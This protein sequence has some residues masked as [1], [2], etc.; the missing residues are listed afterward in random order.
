MIVI[1]FL[2]LVRL[3]PKAVKVFVNGV[4]EVYSKLG[5]IPGCEMNSLFKGPAER[6]L[7][8]EAVVEGEFLM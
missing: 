2:V 6:V 1:I 8:C 7:H 3:L 4:E 5:I